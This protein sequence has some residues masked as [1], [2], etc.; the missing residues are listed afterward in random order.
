ML[1]IK[2]AQRGYCLAKT[3]LE[4]NSI[5]A[6][7]SLPGFKKWV[8]RELLFAP[9]GANINHLHKHWPDAKWEEDAQPVLD[10]YIQS[11]K[12]ADQ[13]HKQKNNDFVDPNDFSFKTK[14]YDHQRKAFYLSRDKES[15]ALLMEQGTGKTKVI[16]DNAAYLYGRDEISALIVIAP[17]GVH[18]NWLSKEIP[19][20]M[21]DWCDYKSVYYYSGISAKDTAK[22][23]D[24]ISA[25]DCLKIF[26]FNCEAFVSKKAVSFMEKIILSNKVMLV[27]DESSRIKTPGAKRTKVITKFSKDVKYRI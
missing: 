19:A 7:S 13:T 24:I 16:I 6:L 11:L 8:G 17:N 2:K 10:K 1:L 5:Q 22:F 26:A 9:T 15:F 25:Q 4:G 12:E 23:N 27:V 21:P 3:K 14:P 20:H 18:R